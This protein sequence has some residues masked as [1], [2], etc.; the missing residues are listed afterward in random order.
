[1]FY[2]VHANH[3]RQQVTHS[4]RLCFL[5]RECI[6]LQEGKHEDK[7]ENVYRQGPQGYM[8]PYEGMSI[9]VSLKKLFPILIILLLS[10]SKD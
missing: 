2:E 10:V 9:P 8:L 1:M 7:K 5:F 6:Q 4:H 3:G